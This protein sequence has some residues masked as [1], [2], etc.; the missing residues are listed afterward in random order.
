MDKIN[1]TD[2]Q[3]KEQLTEEQYRITRLCGTEPPFSGEY[4]NNKNKGLYVCICCG[5][6]LFSS[7]EKFDSGSGWPSYWQPV[8]DDCIKKIVDASHGMR[9][10]EV[11]CKSCD[12]HLGHV[13]EDGPPPTGL[14]FCINSA[15]L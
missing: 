7:D 5:A 8:N 12:A 15:S 4:N 11:R 1:K 13:F 6:E 14:R 9:R 3:W 10:V 2:Q